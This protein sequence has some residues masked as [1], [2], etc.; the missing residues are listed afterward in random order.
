MCPSVMDGVMHSQDAVC[1]YDKRMRRAAEG[2]FERRPAL[3]Y[4]MTAVQHAMQGK[5]IKPRKNKLTV[6]DIW[7]A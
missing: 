7:H 1:L 2:C 5:R 6:S 4:A 3:T